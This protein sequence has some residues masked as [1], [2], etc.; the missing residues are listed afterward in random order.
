MKTIA[1]ARIAAGLLALVVAPLTPVQAKEDSSRCNCWYDGYDA[2]KS[3]EGKS[4][5]TNP[6]PLSSANECDRDQKQK[7]LWSDGCLA[8]A[9]NEARKCPYKSAGD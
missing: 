2:F 4:S 1:L 6:P 3:N 5:C 9:E 8:H 7:Q